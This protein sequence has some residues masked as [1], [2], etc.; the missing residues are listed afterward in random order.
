MTTR[1][2]HS[3]RAFATLATFGVLTAVAACS[4]DATSSSPAASSD[5][6]TTTNADGATTSPQSD[7]STSDAAVTALDCTT[8]NQSLVFSSVSANI[9]KGAFTT[10]PA[11]IKTSSQLFLELKETVSSVERTFDVEFYATTLAV[12]KTFDIATQGAPGGADTAWGS[13]FESGA[14]AP[15][16]GDVFIPQSGKITVVCATADFLGVTLKDVVFAGAGGG[17]G[18][19]DAAAAGSFTAN[20][21]IVAKLVA[22]TR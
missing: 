13:Y 8:A 12:G 6:S 11:G 17:P 3:L 18:A 21:T 5:A 2:L 1:P 16:S 4:S 19:V 20:G 9:Q 14:G 22:G 7:A 15:P 10:P